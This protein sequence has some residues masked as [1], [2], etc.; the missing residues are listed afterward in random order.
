M[1][2]REHQFSREES[3]SFASNIIHHRVLPTAFSPAAE[4]FKVDLRNMNL[5][6]TMASV[7]L[8][9]QS[10]PSA[11][12]RRPPCITNRMQMRSSQVPKG[13]NADL[14]T[15]ISHRKTVGGIQVVYVVIQMEGLLSGVLVGVV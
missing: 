13:G 1:R 11:H 3:E 6:L 8:L 12:T 9:R 4:S 5:G 2:G 7:C 14:L 15:S 10:P